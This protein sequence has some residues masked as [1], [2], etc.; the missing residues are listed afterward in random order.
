MRYF[1]LLRIHH[2]SKNSFLFIP[3]FFAGILT[4][5]DTFLLLVEGFICF[6]LVASA[7]YII[8]D[9][10]DIEKDRLHP[11]KK[12]RPLASNKVGRPIAIALI[13]LCAGAGLAGGWFLNQNFGI[14]LMLYIVINILYSMGLKNV[15]ILD[16]LMVAS[17]FLIRT[18]AGGWLVNVEVSQWLV[19]MVFLLS[20]FLAMAKRRD[21]LILFQDG[22]A[23]LRASSK[24]YTIEFLNTILSVLTGVIIVAY[25]MYT[26]S[27]EVVRHM[28]SKYIYITALFVFGGLMR[29]LQITMVEKRSGSPT[30]IFLTDPFIQITVAGWGLCFAILIYLL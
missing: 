11:T 9:Y 24:N 10:R 8:N 1:F 22:Q 27:D 6:S 7:V 5:W 23:P 14:A 12:N 19:I 29:F 28:G 20:F 15:A 30:R 17:G 25:I 16:T 21:D 2:W 13:F 26:I 18:L 4:D 3:A